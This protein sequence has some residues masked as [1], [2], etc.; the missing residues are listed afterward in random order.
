MS[1]ATGG[2]AKQ[3]KRAAPRTKCTNREQRVSRHFPLSSRC[4]IDYGNSNTWLGL[5]RKQP[6]ALKDTPALRYQPCVRAKSFAIKSPLG[7][8]QICD[9]VAFSLFLAD[10]LAA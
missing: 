6:E 7:A 10:N 8:R 3:E 2:M 5:I 4:F 1:A 9:V